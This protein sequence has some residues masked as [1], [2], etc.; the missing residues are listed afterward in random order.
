MFHQTNDA[1]LFADEKAWQKKGYRL[2]GNIYVKNKK[3]ALPLLE[4]KMTR[5]YDHRASW[6][7]MN[8][9]NA[10][11]NYAAESVSLVD[12][13]NPEFLPKSRYWVAEEHVIERAPES[14]SVAAIGFHDIA[15]ANDTRTMVASLIPYAAYTNTLPLIVNELGEQWRRFC[16]LAG[17]LNSYAYDFVV[18]QKA[19]NAHMNFFIIEQVPTLPPDTYADKCPC[20]KKETLEQWISERVLKLSC[21]ADDMIPLAKACDFKGSRGDGVQLWKESERAELRAELDAAYFHLYN[22]PRPDAEYILSTFTNTGLLRPPERPSQQL[23]FPPG[24]P[25]A[26]ILEAFDRLTSCQ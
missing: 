13:Q 9:K 10:Y 16:C 6:V 17:N 1:A 7:T 18:R 2:A 11:M 23:I 8:P 5:D 15:R 25:G 19:N 3:R 14:L 21:T 4:A 12:H 24:T 20:S 22:I 26:M